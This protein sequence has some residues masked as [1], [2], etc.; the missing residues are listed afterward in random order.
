[1]TFA[2]DLRSGIRALRTYPTLSTVA[3]ITLG[4]GLGLSTTV[5][6]VVNG[7]LFK[8]LPFEE[9]DRV[10]VLFGTKP[11]EHDTYRQIPVQDMP[12]WQSRQTAFDVLGPYSTTSVNL[13]SDEGRPERVSA[14]A[15]IGRGIRRAQGQA[16]ARTR[17]RVWRRSAGRAGGDPL[18]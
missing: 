16:R 15:A 14:G 17:V 7:A 18:G 13:S 5:F 3:I 8:G 12:V 9:P 2:A 11:S 6:C 10:V 4:L 1:M